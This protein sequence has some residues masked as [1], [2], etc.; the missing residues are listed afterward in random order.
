MKK[1]LISMLFIVVAIGL[2]VVSW[3][4][5]PDVVAVQVGIDGKITNTMPKVLAIAIPLGV[6][7]VGSAM[8]LTGKE[9]NKKGYI[10]SVVG[11]AIL[12]VSL[13]FN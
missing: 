4:F 1:N 8:N 5:L 2:G 10:L 7:I 12:I 11:I 3:F 6:S 13:F 9:T